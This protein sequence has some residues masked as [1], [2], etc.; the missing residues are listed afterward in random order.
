MEKYVPDMYRKNI[1]SIDY[2]KLQEQGVKCLLFDLDNTLISYSGKEVEENVKA[3]IE[4]L[5]AK[6]NV[7]IFSNSPKIRLNN[8]KNEFD[9]ECV[10]CARKPFRKNFDRVLSKYKYSENEVAIIGDQLYTDILGGNRVG[11]MTILV[12]PITDV[13][14]FWTRVGRINEKRIVNKLKKHGLFFEG[15]YYEEKM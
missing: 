6:F 7:I 11:I 13:Y 8:F 15:R 2:D 14:P 4:N 9:V 12:S 3:L 1:Y 5:K 10:A